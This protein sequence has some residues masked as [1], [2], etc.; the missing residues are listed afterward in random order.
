MR[1]NDGINET[2]MLINISNDVAS[3]KTKINNLVSTNQKAEKDLQDFNK[4]LG[5]V[6]DEV[7][8]HDSHFKFLYWGLSALCVFLFIGILAPLIV[9]WL[10]KIGSLG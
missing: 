3:I 5:T 2:E 9:D 4:R 6:E 7:K 1:E 8:E 10:A